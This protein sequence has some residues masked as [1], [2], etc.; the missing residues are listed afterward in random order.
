MH[1]ETRFVSG[2]NGPLFQENANEPVLIGTNLS[3]ANE[4]VLIGT[5]VEERLFRA[6]S[7]TQQISAL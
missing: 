3:D 4:P 1:F 2:M 7:R 6:A 5:N